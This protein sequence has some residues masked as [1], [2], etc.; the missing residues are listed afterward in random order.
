MNQEN[1]SIKRVEMDHEKESDVRYRQLL[2]TTLEGILILDA[3]T[4]IIIDINPFFVKMLGYSREE[5]LGKELGE[6]GSFKDTEASLVVFRKLQKKKSIHFEDL[7]LETKDGRRIDVEFVSNACIVGRHRLIQCNL[8]DITEQVR[9]M[10]ALHEREQRFHFTE[11]MANLG[12]WE[13]DIITRKCVWSPGFFHIC[14]FETNAFEPTLEILTNLIHPEDREMVSHMLSR[15]IAQKYGYSIEHRIV[16]SNGMVVWVNSKGE[17]VYD[18]SVKAVKLVGSFLDI[19]ERKQAEEVQRAAEAKYYALIEQ[20]P[21]IT[22]IDQ[23]DGSGLSSFVSPQVESVLGVT[24]DEWIKGDISFW[25]GMI[26]P[27][28]RKR[29]VSAYERTMN[30][31]QPFDEEYRMTARDGRLV[32]INDHAVLLKGATS[33]Q[34]LLHGV[35]FDITERKQAQALQ[36]AV[37]QIAIA[38]E[39]TGSLDDL[40][41]QIHSIISSVMPAENFYI[42]LYDATKNVLRFPYFR[43]V[44]DEPFLAEIEPGKG[45]TAYVLRTGKSLLCTQAVHDELERLGAVKLLGVPSAIWLGVPLIIEGKTIG[46]MV[47]Q[48]YSDPLAYS[49]REQHMLEFVSTQVAIAITRKQAE[50][51]LRYLSTHDVLTGLYNRVFFEEEIA[52]LERGRQFPVSFVMAASL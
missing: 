23:A 12:S 38:A 49:E 13:M 28:D 44:A 48:H 32:W 3:K 17:V 8:R 40:F 39:M 11:R 14:G 37:Y 25:A 50:L 33:Q 51:D 5:C 20:I 15:A 7:P 29:V 45:L 42:T 16:H 35:M 6:I 52:R 46:A 27:E 30:T 18:A 24:Q 4:G 36:Q 43:D 2:E 22:Y 34:N 1:R 31:G 21:A 41:P 9:S 19:T 26:H 47:V 10:E